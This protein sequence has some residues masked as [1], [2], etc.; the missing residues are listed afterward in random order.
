MG[1]G[2]GEGGER[3]VAVG[4]IGIYTGI[5]EKNTF[6]QLIMGT[7]Q[8][9]VRFGS[10]YISPSGKLWTDGSKES[11]RKKKEGLSL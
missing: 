7:K 10:R 4:R 2:R 11:Y 1:A 5:N 8:I 3:G 6:M 9:N